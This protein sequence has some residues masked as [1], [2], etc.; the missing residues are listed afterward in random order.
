MKK[1]LLL[2]TLLL[3]MIGGGVSAQTVSEQDAAAKAM[4]FWKTNARLAPGSKQEVKLSLAHKAANQ[5]ETYFYIF[6]NAAGGFVI[7]GG[8]EVAEEVL[9]YCDH[10]S[11][12]YQAIPANF[13]WLL[14]TYEQSISDGIHAVKEHGVAARAPKRAESNWPNISP[15]LNGI[16]W[17]QALPY[18]A[19]IPGNSVD[20][21]ANNQYATGCV[22]T[23][24]AQIMMYWQYPEHGWSSKSYS[25]NGYTYEANFAEATY[26]WGV[27]QKTYTDYVYNG[28]PAEQEVAKLLYHVGVASKMNYDIIAH[29]GS[30]TSTIQAARGMR[31]FFGYKETSALFRTSYSDDDWETLVYNELY[32]ERPVL[33]SGTGEGGHAFVCDGYENGKFYINWGWGGEFNGPFLLTATTTSTE[34]PLTPNGT[35]IGGGVVGSSYVDDQTIIVGL[36][37]DPEYDGGLSLVEIF[38][39]NNGNYS[40]D[41]DF[42]IYYEFNNSSK[43]DIEIDFP[44]MFFYPGPGFGST[45]FAG[46]DAVV[47]PA[48]SSEIIEITEEGGKTDCLK[49]PGSLIAQIGEYRVINP[50]AGEV[51][52]TLYDQFDINI[53]EPLEITYTLSAA[54]WGTLCLPFEAEVPAGLTAYKVTGVEGEKLVKEEVDY[55]EMNTPYLLSGN[56]GTYTFN[57]PDTPVGTEWKSGVMVG[58]TQASSAEAPVY[59]PKGS[60]VL[61]VNDGNLGFYNVENDNS[62][63]IRQY[64]A[65]LQLSTGS[66]GSFYAVDV[67]DGIEQIETAESNGISYQINGM[68]LNGQAKGLSVK[69]GRIMFNK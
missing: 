21:D 68:R 51:Y 13:R 39:P 19:S 6:N 41:E 62:Q 46:C 67:T 37:P 45:G 61:Q 36:E 50:E 44:M 16:E 59:A 10:G 23:A 52:Y 1:Q 40:M 7:I 17:N 48:Q 65:Y 28:T 14:S 12:D 60:Y 66:N 9:G 20:L 55:L 34:K 8:D 38:M 3:S 53:C 33:Y 25:Q 2:G 15:L 22:A 56:E 35:G 27:M 4:N 18:N 47:I 43:S 64:S 32:N 42:R 5:D 63:R 57:G 29:G 31:D 26:N 69:N 54:G 58:N 30:G 24:A 11:F 49:S